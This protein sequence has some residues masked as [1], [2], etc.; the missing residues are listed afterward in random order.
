M[1]RVSHHF[2]FNKKN[3]QEDN[4]VQ[5]YMTFSQLSVV[6]KHMTNTSPHIT[7][8]PI[9]SLKTQLAQYDHRLK[10]LP[11]LFD[12]SPTWNPSVD[13]V[14]TKRDPMFVWW[15]MWA[16]IG[17]QTSGWNQQFYPSVHI[18]GVRR[19]RVIKQCPC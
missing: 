5:R 10:Q 8:R 12:S 3:N 14:K 19:S 4:Y 7:L 11:R 9:S 15:W 13:Q 16:L 17:Y 1:W 6:W 18:E 2:Y